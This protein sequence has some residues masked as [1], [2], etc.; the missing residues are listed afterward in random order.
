MVLRALVASSHGGRPGARGAAH[1]R[2]GAPPIRDAGRRQT[3]ALGQ[4]RASRGHSGQ[5]RITG[6][7]G[8]GRAG[9]GGDPR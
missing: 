1:H 7:E 9:A 4:R 8:R 6:G 2:Q 5:G 3:S